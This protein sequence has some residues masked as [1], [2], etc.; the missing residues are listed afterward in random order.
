MLHSLLSL[1]VT[2]LGWT[3]LRVSLTEFRLGL[4]ASRLAREL[5]YHRAK[6]LRSTLLGAGQS[7]RTH[8]EAAKSEIVG[9]I[10]QSEA[11]PSTELA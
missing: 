9:R 1:K 2:P 10:G 3:A 8:S 5:Q 11:H 6:S 4:G 7:F